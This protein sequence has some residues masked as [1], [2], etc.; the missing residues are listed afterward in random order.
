MKVKEKVFI[1]LHVF[2]ISIFLFFY[3]GS[4]LFFLINIIPLVMFFIGG[5]E[6]A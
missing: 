4:L 1:L 3:F 2:I 6:D 5:K